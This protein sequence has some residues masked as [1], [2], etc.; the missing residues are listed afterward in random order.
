MTGVIINDPTEC[1]RRKHSR[2]FEDKSNHHR[3]LS[4]GGGWRVGEGRRTSW[5]AK[6][7]SSTTD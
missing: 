5:G 7:A 4:Q 3:Q 1:M 2:D 6:Q